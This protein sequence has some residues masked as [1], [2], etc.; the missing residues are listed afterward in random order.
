MDGFIARHDDPIWRRWTPPCGYRC[1]CSTI[2]LSEEQARRRGLNIQG[3]PPNVEPDAGWDYDRRAGWREGM[4]RAV[5]TRTD[6]CSPR[7]FAPG[8][9]PRGWCAPGPLRNAMDAVSARLGDDSDA[10]LA[11]ALRARYSDNSYDF[12]VEQ[13]SRRGVLGGPLSAAEAVSMMIWS[14]NSYPVIG[15][16]LRALGIGQAAT[17][18]AE[19]SAVIAGIDRALRKLPPSSPSEV[20]RGFNE[21]D[22][23]VGVRDQF[24]RAHT[25]NGERF[26]YNSFTAWT[27]DQTIA[28]EGFADPAQRGWLMFLQQPLQL[29]DIRA[30][31]LSEEEAEHLAPMFR[32]YEVISVDTAKR[33]ITVKE[34]AEGDRTSLPADRNF[35]DSEAPSA[36]LGRYLDDVRAGRIK[37][38]ASS[39]ARR[40]IIDHM[41][42]G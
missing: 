29:R 16:V 20:F 10:I 24:M 26:Q 3:A 11:S 5:K 40:R 31:S 21:S 41:R 23:P 6:R 30:Y 22:L 32:Q 4:R 9:G 33:T 37:L 2:A 7:T 8:T 27:T 15:R 38:P 42:F 35:A 36:A 18:W 1:R 39:E 34:V 14:G 19:V 28:A 12:Y 25:T 17:E 13:L